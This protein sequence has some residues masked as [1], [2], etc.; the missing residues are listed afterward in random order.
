MDKSQNQKYWRQTLK[1]LTFTCK[2][3]TLTLQ[4]ILQITYLE[5]QHIIYKIFE[6]KYQLLNFKT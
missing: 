5:K 1:M 3:Y 6:M 2:N 4:A